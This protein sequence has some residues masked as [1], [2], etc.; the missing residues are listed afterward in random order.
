MGG[1]GGGNATPA[2]VEAGA[3]ATGLMILA[4]ALRDRGSTADT[5]RGDGA[6]D[7]VDASYGRRD[8]GSVG[9]ALLLPLLL[10]P[11][12]LNGAGAG[13]VP[14]RLTAAV[15]GGI[16]MG[17][18]GGGGGGNSPPPGAGPTGGRGAYKVGLAPAKGGGGGGGSERLMDGSVELLRVCDVIELER[19]AVPDAAGAAVRVG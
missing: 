2:A 13:A 14:I 17:G 10:L 18:G 7:R 12:A 8:N 6:P 3:A 4:A 15:G 19:L 1:G 16:A 11:R 9:T 5:G